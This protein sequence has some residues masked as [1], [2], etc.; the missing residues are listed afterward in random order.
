MILGFGAAPGACHASDG[1]DT[2]MIRIRQAADQALF[3]A[4]LSPDRIDLVF[5][6]M[7]GMDWPEEKAFLEEAIAANLGNKKVNVTNDCLI[8]M[9]AGTADHY[10]AV[11]C[12]GSGMNCAACAP[13]GKKYIYGYYVKDSDQGGGALS[14]AAIQAVFDAET[15]FSPPTALT[16][17]ILNHLG[18]STVDELLHRHVN[19]RLDKK[20][21]AFLPIVL[22]KA[23]LEGITAAADIYS[24]YGR[25]WARYAGLALRRLDLAAMA[26]DV[27]V[28]GSIFKCRAPALLNAFTGELAVHA[29]LARVVE[30]AFEPVAGAY[31]LALEQLGIFSVQEEKLKETPYPLLRR[32]VS[33]NA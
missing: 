22:E 23:A 13:D 6:G 31:L 4:G 27:V 11:V 17:L 15:G 2:A 3:R 19:G 8:A 29:P 7:A 1:I 5:A 16:P 20:T 10:G 14:N 12:A 24:F 30:A 26:V 28:S 21:R 33:G 25:R 18:C 9:R 32:S